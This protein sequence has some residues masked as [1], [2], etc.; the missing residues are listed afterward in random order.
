MATDFRGLRAETLVQQQRGRVLLVMDEYLSGEFEYELV[1]CQIGLSL[2]FVVEE[3]SAERQERAS[4]GIIVEVQWVQEQLG[5]S[6]ILGF[7][8]VV[9]KDPG[10]RHFNREL[11]SL[12]IGQLEE[13]L[14]EPELGHITAFE[15]RVW[16]LDC[17]ICARWNETVMW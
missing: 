6:W 1:E 13:E 17:V 3:P 10:N 14:A 16:K 15:D 12:S 5:E 7:E 9:G 2:N 8:N 11:H 4:R